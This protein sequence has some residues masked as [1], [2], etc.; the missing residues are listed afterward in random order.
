VEAARAALEPQVAAVRDVRDGQVGVGLA[1]GGADGAFGGERVRH[2]Y[3]CKRA[4]GGSQAQRDDFRPREVFFLSEASLVRTGS[5]VDPAQPTQEEERLPP[6]IVTYSRRR[7]G[8]W[9]AVAYLAREGALRT[10]A[11]LTGSWSAVRRAGG[12]A[13]RLAGANGS[14]RDELAASPLADDGTVL[15]ALDDTALPP[16]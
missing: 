7:D 8:S 5:G 3:G 12:V 15:G 13:S 14:S 11:V 16:K 4:Y 2:A 1:A 9:L 6:Y 10:A